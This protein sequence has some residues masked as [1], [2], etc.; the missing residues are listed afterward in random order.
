MRTRTASLAS[1]LAGTSAAAKAGRLTIGAKEKS[2]RREGKSP[3][4]PA[5]DSR[6]YTHAY[7]MQVR[8]PL[9]CASARQARITAQRRAANSGAKS[10][11][12]GCL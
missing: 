8:E 6:L 7:H 5:K 3:G 12:W 9:T 2:G 4:V 10:C 1:I 11:G